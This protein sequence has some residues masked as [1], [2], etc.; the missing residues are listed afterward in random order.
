MA[1][2]SHPQIKVDHK[3]LKP[4]D[5]YVK[6]RI[7]VTCAQHSVCDIVIFISNSFFFSGKTENKDRKSVV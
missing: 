5:S 3:P 7:V 2:T 4:F 6:S 1:V